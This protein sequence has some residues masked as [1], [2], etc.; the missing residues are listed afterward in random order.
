MP[1]WSLLTSRDEHDGVGEKIA[2]LFQQTDDVVHNGRGI[3]PDGER[4][5][6]IF[7][8]GVDAG[9]LHARAVV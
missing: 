1:R 9:K 2:I 4:R 7:G 8:H 5:A 3:M 6:V